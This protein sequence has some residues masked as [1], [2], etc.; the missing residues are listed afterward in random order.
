MLQQRLTDVNHPDHTLITYPGLG[1]D[2]SSAIGYFPGSA[3]YGLQKVG[4]SIEEYVLA[5]LYSWL[6]AHS[7]LSHPYVT[8]VSTIGVNSSSSSSR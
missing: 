3:M 4:G 7:G 2:F 6:E 1:H 5:D 8:S